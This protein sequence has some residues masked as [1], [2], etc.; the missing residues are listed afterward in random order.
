[1]RVLAVEPETLSFLRIFEV[2]HMW[3]H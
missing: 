1:L 3:R 2:G